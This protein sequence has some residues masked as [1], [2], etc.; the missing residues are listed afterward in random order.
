[1]NGSLN[2]LLQILAASIFEKIVNP[3]DFFTDIGSTFNKL[4]Q[5]HTAMHK[6]PKNV[7]GFLNLNDFPC[8]QIMDIIFHKPYLPSIG[9]YS[10]FLHVLI[11]RMNIVFLR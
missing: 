11:D 7:I 1:M 4:I 6:H 3:I 10:V 5:S 2:I 8:A 9:C